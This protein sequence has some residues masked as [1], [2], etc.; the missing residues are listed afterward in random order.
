M[1][2]L[3]GPVFRER[4]RGVKVSTADFLSADPGS[5]PGGSAFS[6][7]SVQYTVFRISVC[8]LNTEHFLLKQGRRPTAGRWIP[9][10][11]IVVQFRVPLPSNPN[12]KNYEPNRATT[13]PGDR[14][15]CDAR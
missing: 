4:S 9:N 11:E 13:D 14:A 7:Y 6:V 8:T 3:P 5:S 15:A 2:V 10:P 12:D 1:Q